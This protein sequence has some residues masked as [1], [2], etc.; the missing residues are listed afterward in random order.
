MWSQLLPGA[1]VSLVNFGIHALMTGAI[2]EVTRR[3]AKRTDYNYWIIDGGAGPGPFTL[4]TTDV[5]GRT[6]TVTGIKLRPGATQKTSTRAG[7]SGPV[8]G[9]P[10]R[11]PAK[12]TSPL[13]SPSKVTPSSAA[14]VL[15]ATEAPTSAPPAVALA[16]VPEAAAC[17]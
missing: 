14:P 16:A 4:R 11:A 12:K 7:G 6:T 3:T 15:R 2:I 1:V 17:G 10:K 9:T 5:Y 8:A 13:P